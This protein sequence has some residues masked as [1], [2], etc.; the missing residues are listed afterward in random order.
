MNSTTS[1][2]LSREHIAFEA[3]KCIGRLEFENRNV[4]SF[5]LFTRILAKIF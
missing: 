4:I 5:V 2:D 1:D 3:A